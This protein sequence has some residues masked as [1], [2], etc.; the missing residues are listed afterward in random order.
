M[1]AGF[2][3][4]LD[5]HE[6]PG[7]RHPGQRL[8]HHRLEPGEHHDV[9]ANPDAERDD[10]DG[11][12]Q[13]HPGNRAES[14]AGVAGEMIKE[15]QGDSF[16]VLRVSYRVTDNRSDPCSPKPQPRA[17]QEIRRQGD[18]EN[19]FSFTRKNS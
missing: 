3:T 15:G 18:Q 5:E 9:D 17:L 14:V 10:D 1:R 7:I 16:H 4:G 8:Q 19:A 12:Q 2:R 13:W 6:L 11:G